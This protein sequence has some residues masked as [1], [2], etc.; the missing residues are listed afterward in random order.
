MFEMQSI[1][2]KQQ[3]CAALLPSAHGRQVCF[4]W[5][6]VICV[7]EEKSKKEKCVYGCL[8]MAKVLWLFN[9]S[10]WMFIFWIISFSEDLF[11]AEI[12]EGVCLLCFKSSSWLPLW[13][14]WRHHDHTHTHWRLRIQK[15]LVR[16]FSVH[17]NTKW[18]YCSKPGE[19]P[20]FTNWIC[21]SKR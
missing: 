15:V 20:W 8:L 16:M 4:W 6:E 21:D 1:Q 9:M 11:G 18:L 12:F 10:G 17:R 3:F 19:I 2:S 13:E 5:A 7:Y 14:E